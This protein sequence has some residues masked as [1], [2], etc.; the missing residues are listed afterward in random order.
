MSRAVANEVSIQRAYYSK[1]SSQYDNRHLEA[2]GEHDFALAFMI[3][4]I[5]FLEIRSVLDVGS[6]TGRALIRLK[7]ARPN[8]A[9]VG[10][11]PSGELRAVGYSKGLSNGELV[12]GDA[13]RLAYADRS[14]D[15][16]C[17][18]AALHHIPNPARAVAEMLRVASKAVFISDS[19]NFGS[20]SFLS[21]TTKQLLRSLGLWSVADF[22]KTRG[23]GY[24]ITE[25]DG[26]AYSYSV[27]NDYLQIAAACKSVHVLNTTPAG[28]NAYR[29]SSQVALLGIK[30]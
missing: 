25:G 22:V 11:E 16:V 30:H 29:S 23:R 13:Q 6:G 28:R 12:D 24:S 26:L 15:L 5:D 18:F 20:G 17:E 21:R 3:S 1:T 19:N 2:A 4:L 14:F 7:D 27:F 10:I 8:L 9:V